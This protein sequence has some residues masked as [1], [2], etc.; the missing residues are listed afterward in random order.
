MPPAIRRNLPDDANERSKRLEG[1]LADVVGIAPSW[2]PLAAAQSA[3]RRDTR[4]RQAPSD[5][6]TDHN[7]PRSTWIIQQPPR[8]IKD[9][10]LNRGKKGGQSG[11]D[12]AGMP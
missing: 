1:D 2:L 4:C 3:A 7:F 9:V 5:A 6:H 11:T 12:R 10:R 8:D